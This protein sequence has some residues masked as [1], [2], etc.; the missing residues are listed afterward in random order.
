M[1]ELHASRVLFDVATTMQS[2]AERPILAFCY[3]S[4]RETFAFRR[5]TFSTAASHFAAL[6]GPSDV[7]LRVTRK[8][9]S[10]AGKQPRYDVVVGVIWTPTYLA[11]HSPV[12]NHPFSICSVIQ[13]WSQLPGGPGASGQVPAA[14]EISNGRPGNDR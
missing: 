6:F 4:E 1:D 5:P 13:P 7:E 3:R 2:L 14:L 9:F 12:T 8:Y 10:L 11:L